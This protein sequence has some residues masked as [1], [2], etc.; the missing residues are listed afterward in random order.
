MTQKTA[1]YEEHL[2]LKARMVDFAGWEMP[3]MYTSIMDEHRA[4]RTAA[5]LFDVSHMAEVRLLGSNAGNFLKKLIPTR[6]D[7][8]V[9]FKSMYS[10]FCNRN[11][12]VIDDLFVY[13][14]N[15]SEYYL[16]LN[17]GTHEKDIGWL[18]ENK[19]DGVQIIDESAET[20]K[21]DIQGPASKDLMSR[22]FAGQNIE[23]LKRFNFSTYSYKGKKVLIFQSGYT[24]EF[25][26]E[27]YLENSLAGN[28]WND[29]LESGARNG[30][31]PVGLGARDTLRLESCYSLY[32]HELN[33]SINPVQ[34]G[35]KWVVSSKENYIAK[36]ILEREIAA[37]AEKELI[38]FVLEGKGVPREGCRVFLNDHDE[39]H[40][41]SG[42]FSPTFNKGLG[43]ALVKSG[44]I[45]IG[46]S[47]DIMIRD[48]K[49][50]AVSVVRPFYKYNG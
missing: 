28:I 15:E 49:V 3:V 35:L 22:L 32:G 8:L 27:I 13:M 9:P 43:M 10:V 23:K 41:T 37:G 21:I 6:L 18:M 20:S 16:V 4:T 36:D 38:T 5:G 25:G 7:K 39:G 19:I 1:L 45:K 33:D 34:A 42:G 40:V 50:P 31:V 46:D 2:K 24:G 11:G 30:I 29:L 44:K 12:G 48:K 17:A 47:F 26:Y 14:V